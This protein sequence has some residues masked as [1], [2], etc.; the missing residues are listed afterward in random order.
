MRRYIAPRIKS[1]P[2]QRTISIVRSYITECFLA[3]MCDM[4]NHG[5]NPEVEVAYDPNTG[6]CYAYALIDVP[7]GSPLRISYGDPTDTTPLFANYGF[8]DDT[9][10][11][12]FCKLMH[13][14]NEME[15]LGY[16][17]SD[18]LFYKDGNISPEV[19]DVVLYHVLKKSDDPDL[20]Q[21]FYQ[22]TM[23]GDEST[24]AQYQEQYWPYTR[25]ELQNHVNGLI[26]DIDRWSRTARSYDV[27]THPRAPLI[28]QH[29]AF[30]RDTFVQVKSYL[31][32]M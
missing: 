4:F 19:Y 22:A 15:E 27:N 17:F 28:L 6:D 16:G 30:V 5:A 18:L 21:G 10:P 23:S 3:P 7:A 24:K 14:L 11:G 25:E 13:M 1:T 20:V 8:L 31:D 12:T 2:N 26:D 29:N 32:S 9:A